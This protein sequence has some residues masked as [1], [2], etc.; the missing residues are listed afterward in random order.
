M[1]SEPPQPLATLLPWREVHQPSWPLPTIQNVV[2]TVNLDCR[3]DLK[4]LG[5]HA[6][7]VEYKPSR[8][9][10]LIMRIRDPRTTSLVFASG[11]LVLTGAKSEALARLATRKHARAIQK[12]GFNAQFKEF[13]VQNFVGSAATGFYVRLEGI[14]SE[15][16][17]FARYEPEVFPGL[18]FKRAGWPVSCL[19]FANGKVVLTGAK[20]EEQVFDTFVRLYPILLDFKMETK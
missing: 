2:A 10:A 14:A 11:K 6:R 8:F 19:V 12:A 9:S 13:K 5:Q 18:V 20:T 1:S 17:Q 3:I 7:N 15:F 4:L 16:Y